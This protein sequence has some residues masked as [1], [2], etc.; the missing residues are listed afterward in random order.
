VNW[1]TG[2]P[3]QAARYAQRFADLE[4]S[5]AKVHGE[6]DFVASFD[7]SSVL[8]AGCGTG[9]VAIELARRGFDVCGADRDAAMLDVARRAAPHLSWVEGDLGDPLFDLGRRFAV[10]VAAGNV[11]LF[12]TPGTEGEVVRTLARHVQ[13]GGLLIAGFQLH[14]IGV[15]AYDA[16][17]TTAG[18][19]LVERFATWDRQPFTGGEY[20]V[21]VHRAASTG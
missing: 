21:S 5:G 10:V 17:T 2:D 16:L 19:S 3:E 7:P 20:A 9:R 6:A 13:P 8:D 18:L 4:A 1:R 12:V 11:L 15:D 14:G